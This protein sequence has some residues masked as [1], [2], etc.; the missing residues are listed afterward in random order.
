MQKIKKLRIS[1]GILILKNIKFVIGSSLKSMLEKQIFQDLTGFS[2]SKLRG[3]TNFSIQCMLKKLENALIS[4]YH[5]S[6]PW[7]I[8]WRE[9][10]RKFL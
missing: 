8:F 3:F 6:R 2:S 9:V 1:T 4:K 5:N 7:G 10:M